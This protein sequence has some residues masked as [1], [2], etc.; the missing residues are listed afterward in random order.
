MGLPGEALQHRLNE[1]EKGNKQ[2]KRKSVN[3][4]L[5]ISRF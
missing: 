3:V 1:N 4:F 5:I 2:E